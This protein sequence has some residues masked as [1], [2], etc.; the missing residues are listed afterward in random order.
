ME[1]FVFQFVST[2]PL[3]L[4]VSLGTTEQGLALSSLL[5]FV[6]YL[7]I[8]ITPLLPSFLFSSLNSHSSLSLS[9]FDRCSKPWITLV[10]LCCTCS[11]L[12]C[13][14]CIGEPST[15]H[16]TPDVA[17][18]ILRRGQL[19]L[20]AP[21][22]GAFPNLSHDTV[23]ILCPAG[24]SAPFL[25]SYF[26]D[27]GSTM[28]TGAQ[29]SSSADADFAFPLHLNFLRFLSAHLLACQ[30]LSE[31]QHPHL[32]LQTVLS[33]AYDGMD[34]ACVFITAICVCPLPLYLSVLHHLKIC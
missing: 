10:A 20:P 5:P 15:A 21:D 17:S 9:Q 27:C 22:R 18:S 31:Q 12:K 23:G 13:L 28:C 2:A 24:N 29:G 11:I 8:L 4:V 19:S 26:P 33:V 30:G 7:H 32:M 6:T 25:Q 1:L 14:T 3:P 16:S 34:S